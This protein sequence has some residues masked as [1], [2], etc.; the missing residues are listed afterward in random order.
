M[1]VCFYY[2]FFRFVEIA[3]ITN[4][5]QLKADYD[6]LRYIVQNDHCYTPYT[7]ADTVNEASTTAKSDS[8]SKK[9]AKSNKA[10]AKGPAT[11]ATNVSA[12]KPGRSVFGSK[13]N[14][15]DASDS[16]N[17]RTAEDANSSVDNTERTSDEEE[18]ESETDFSDF[19]EDESDND[20]DSDLDFSVND[21]HSRRA[22][23]MIKKKKAQAKRLAGRKRRQSTIDVGS[24]DGLTPNRKKVPKKSLNTS[25]KTANAA[26]PKVSSSIRSPVASSTPRLTKVIKTEVSRPSELAE[27]N[28]PTTPKA[29]ERVVKEP[30]KVSVSEPNKSQIIQKTTITSTT[31]NVPSTTN[32]IRSKSMIIVR[33]QSIKKPITDT[34][35][36]FNARS[37][38][39]KSD[40]S[41]N[42]QNPTSGPFMMKPQP[43]TSTS[44]VTNRQTATTVQSSSIVQATISTQAN[45]HIQRPIINMNKIR[46]P[47][48][49][50]ES[51]QD[52]QLDLINSLVQ[53]ELSKSVIESKAPILSQSDR[54]IKVIPAAIPSIVKMLQTPETSTSIQTAQLPSMR[55]TASIGFDPSADSQ[56]LPDDLLESFVN[57]DDCLTDDLMQHVVKLVEDKNIQEVLDQQVLGVQ[58]IVS[59]PLSTVVPSTTM[60]VPQTHHTT[61]SMNTNIFTP[62]S[63]IIPMRQIQSKFVSDDKLSSINRTPN[64][65]REPILI[66]KS[67]GQIITL[68]PIEA[69]ATRGAKRRAEGTPTNPQQ[70]QKVITVIVQSES[71][72]QPKVTTTTTTTIANHEKKLDN[73]EADNAIKAKPITP[74][75][76]R[77]SVAVKRTT[78][79]SKPKRSMSISNPPA[80]DDDNDDDDDGSDGSYNSEDDPHR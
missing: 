29:L 42:V 68:P 17:K 23:K 62:K 71:S 64:Y 34:N 44:A 41:Q 66:K 5:K 75:E 15:L 16:G 48:V 73:N 14:G 46:T 74:R 55:T 79:D 45:Q 2:F 40:V 69:P 21:A 30:V 11:S 37:T 56:M 19:T 32:P 57:S 60:N 9:D 31:T 22:K 28:A 59:T 54:S 3:G 10:N 36:S 7:H 50:L 72:Q 80:T 33:Q 4:P 18:A 25:L 20:R 38:L 47:T 51:E 49:K 6:H 52:K 78:F 43:S 76:R 39:L 8:T 53:E 63:N 35:K 13:S 67:N 24:D 77:A 1:I 27:A 61:T 58:P 65:R 26:T 70:K 12:K